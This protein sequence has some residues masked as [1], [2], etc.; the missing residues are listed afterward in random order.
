M[1]TANRFG[2]FV[3]NIGYLGPSEP[4]QPLP[5][6]GYVF[7][8][9]CSPMI[10]LQGFNSL[11]GTMH[12]LP[13][14]FNGVRLLH[15]GIDLRCA[16]GE[17]MLAAQSGTVCL[18][19]TDPRSIYGNCIYL[20]HE[21]G[22]SCSFYSHLDQILVREGEALKQA[23]T[24]AKGGSSCFGRIEPGNEHLHFELRAGIFSNRGCPNDGTLPWG[25]PLH[26][27][28]EMNKSQN[29]QE[30]FI[31]YLKRLFGLRE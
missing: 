23:Q 9:R 26:K 15:E 7:P 14:S 11:P 1:K 31:R 25:L 6:R 21:N 27:L 22:K 13:G 24:I 4:P 28:V 18:C 29:E 30:R 12:Q 5:N 20:N 8:L 19:T 2:D 16:S 10:L 3:R 17:E